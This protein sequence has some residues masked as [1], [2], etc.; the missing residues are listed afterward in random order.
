MKKSSYLETTG[1][2]AVVW[3]Y[4][5]KA[6]S[7]S[8]IFAF[9]SIVTPNAA[10]TPVAS[11]AK[12]TYYFICHYLIQISST[13]KIMNL[14]IYIQINLIPEKLIERNFGIINQEHSLSHLLDWRK[15]VQ[16]GVAQSYHTTSKCIPAHN[17]YKLYTYMDFWAK[18]NTN[19]D[20]DWIL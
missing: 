10:P 3:R 12:I 11:S 5:S 1:A 15:Q 17:I 13:N 20:G 8:S 14:C 2:R 19:I 9:S 4:T 7:N 18:K 16:E 6:F